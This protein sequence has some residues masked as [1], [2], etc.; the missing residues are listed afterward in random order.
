[1]MS[2]V[3]LG[4]A[5]AAVAL[6]QNK[7]Q[8]SGIPTPTGDLKHKVSVTFAVLTDRYCEVVVFLQHGACVGVKT[9]CAFPLP[10]SA[11]CLFLSL[12]LCAKGLD[13]RRNTHA[14]EDSLLLD[15]M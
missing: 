13:K 2:R 5:C 12:P 11:F 6:A 7:V 14:P 15:S 3:V 1:M 9:R 4:L 8:W 10:R